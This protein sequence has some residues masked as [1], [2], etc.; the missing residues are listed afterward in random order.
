MN[1]RPTSNSLETV[2]Y[3]YAYKIKVDVYSLIISFS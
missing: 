1:Y 3:K 2:N